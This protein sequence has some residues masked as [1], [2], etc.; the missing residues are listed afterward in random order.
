MSYGIWDQSALGA[1]VQ[2]FPKTTEG[3]QAAWAQFSSWEPAAAGGA[4]W[5]RPP[6]TNGKAV[7]SLVLG[8]FWMR[9]IGSILALVFGYKGKKEI[10][11]SQGTQDGRGFAVAGIV[12]GWIGIVGLVLIVLAIALPTF[13][14]VRARAQ[15][16]VSQ[17]SARNAAAAAQVCWT[18]NDSYESCGASTLAQI[19]Y[20]LAFIDGA[21]DS[22]G[23]SEVSVDVAGSNRIT[24]AALSESGTCFYLNEDATSG[25]VGLP[26]PPGC[27]PPVLPRTLCSR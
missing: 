26:T 10:E 23:P 2:R 7:A 6:Q 24:F 14:G 20:S 18:D 8:V 15:D 17:A 3:W 19:E 13:L 27:L 11:E 4:A 5:G 9:G 25:L 12:L 22:T 16:K 21:T 1:P